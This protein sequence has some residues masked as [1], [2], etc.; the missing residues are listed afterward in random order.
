MASFESIQRVCF[1]CRVASWIGLFIW[2]S[3]NLICMSCVVDRILVVCY[4]CRWPRRISQKILWFAQKTGIIPINNHS[5]ELWSRSSKPSISKKP[6]KIAHKT[7]KCQPS[8]FHHSKP[9]LHMFWKLK[10]GMYLFSHKTRHSLKMP[11]SLKNIQEP[12]KI[13]LR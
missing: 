5:Y 8:W 6:P 9:K 4:F 3:E 7:Q 2:S 13:N 12:S 1:V 10:V 11:S